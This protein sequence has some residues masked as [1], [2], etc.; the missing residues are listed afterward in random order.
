MLKELNQ[1]W[2]LDALFPGGSESSEYAAYLEALERDIGALTQ[3]VSTPSGEA[4]IPLWSRRLAIVQDLVIRLRQ[5]AAFVTCLNAQNVKDYKARLLGSRVKQIQA[6]YASALTIMDEQLLKIPEAEWEGLL[7]GGELRPLAFNLQERRR[8]AR[9]KLSPDLETLANDLAVDG[10]HGWSELYDTVVGRMSIPVPEN[11]KTVQVSPGQ[12][13]NRMSSPDPAVRQQVMANWEAAWGDVAEFCAS[14]LNH[15]AGFRLNLYHRRGWDSPLKEPLEINRMSRETLEA[16]WNAVNQNKERLVTYLKRKQKLLGLDQLSWPDVSA[17]IGRSETKFTYDEAANFIVEQF[18]R[19]DPRLAQFA[20][21]AFAQ[22]WIEAEDRP[23]KRPGGFCTSFPASRQSRIFVTFSGTIG[24]LSTL[25][26][27]LGH[28]YHQHVMND[29]PPLAQQYAMNVAETAST[30][31]Q[32]I[33]SDA[34]TK[35]AK[36][37]NERLFLIED[38]L[39]DSASLL[40]NIQ[41]RFL[42]ET[43]FYEA[44]QRGPLGVPALNELMVNAQKEAFQDAL[45]VYH[46]HFWASKLHFYSTNT[47]FYNFPYTFGFLFST[48]V[49][50]RA[51]EEGPAFADRYVELLR[52][53]G[54]MRVEDL[55]LHHLGADLTKAAFWQESIDTAL[56]DLEE[57]LRLTDK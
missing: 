47:P 23:G 30:F 33:V 43:R 4:G 20:A 25:A 51:R 17:P 29:L 3:D 31:A 12:A 48:G 45:G 1:T 10:Y 11:G 19:F 57:F 53:T 24:N 2:N 27:E 56:A 54:R 6:N 22:R 9:E 26:H 44:R 34:A 55:A 8:R 40:M 18:G 5:A 42:F 38:R 39:A 7:A 15:L 13:A 36:D 32:L 49:Y 37:E 46:P 14:A 21:K 41:S 28:A 52:D 50:T 35:Q 16:M